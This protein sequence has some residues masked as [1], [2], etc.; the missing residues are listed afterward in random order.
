VLGATF[1]M[2]RPDRCEIAK[3][4]Y[5]GNGRR[6][7]NEDAFALDVVAMLAREADA[8]ID[9][10]AYTGVFT[11]ATA[12]VNPILTSHAYEIVPA[13][14]DLLEDNVR[15]NGF[16]ERVFVHREGIGVPG[17]TMVIP[18]GEGGSALPSFY[19]S[20]LRFEHG[21][22]VAF[23]SLDSLGDVVGPAKRLVMKVDV[24]GTEDDIFAHGQRFLAARRPDVLCEVLPGKARVEALNGLLSRL[25]YEFYLVRGTDLLRCALISPHPHYRDWLFAHRERSITSLGLLVQQEQR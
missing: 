20:R 6:P 3:E 18:S 1:V 13:V 16:G 4:F 22:T 24:E 21:T 12:S 15:R 2:L 14:A 17:A 9:I 8:F 23:R 10:G 11:L 7:R 19:S 5:W 25:G